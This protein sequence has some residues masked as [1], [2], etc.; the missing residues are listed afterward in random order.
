LV[1]VALSFAQVTKSGTGYLMRMKWSKGASYSYSIT[2]ATVMNGQ[3]FSMPMTLVTKVDSVANGIANV[4][5]TITM[6]GQTQTMKAKMD[7]RGVVGGVEGMAG[8]NPPKLPEKAVTVGSTWKDTQNIT[9]GGMSL[10][11]ETTYTFK[12][13]ETVGKV[14]CA[15]LDVVTSVTGSMPAKGTGKM[16]VEV[17]TGQLYKGNVNTTMTMTAGGKSQTIQSTMTIARK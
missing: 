9:Q 7:G 13:L 8:F 10:K 2:N 11:T 17:A 14:S 4:T 16:Y 15:V 6:N 12:G 3:S 1:V 5:N